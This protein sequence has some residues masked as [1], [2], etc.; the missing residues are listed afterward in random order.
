MDRSVPVSLFLFGTREKSIWGTCLISFEPPRDTSCLGT[1]ASS[2]SYGVATV[3]KAL[4]VGIEFFLA[5]L[6]IDFDSLDHLVFRE[7][8]FRV[9]RT[10]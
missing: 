2:F 8:Q 3:Q 9:S 10:G 1:S 6:Q 5:H 4:R 7:L